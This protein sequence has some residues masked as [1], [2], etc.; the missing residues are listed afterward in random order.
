MTSNISIGAHS[1]VAFSFQHSTSAAVKVRPRV[2]ASARLARSRRL[3]YRRARRRAWFSSS[4]ASMETTRCDATRSTPSSRSM[5]RDGS[6]WM[7]VHRS[8][9]ARVLRARRSRPS[10]GTTDEKKIYPSFPRRRRPSN[11][12]LAPPSRVISAKPPPRARPPRCVT[13][14]RIHS[15]PDAR[16]RAS[17]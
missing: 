14:S 2:R 15:S 12:P 11:S 9:C 16:A 5:D 13:H 7:I 3:F 10:S 17:D 6:R 4:R 1:R 8:G